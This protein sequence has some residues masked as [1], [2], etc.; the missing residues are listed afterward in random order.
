MEHSAYAPRLGT[1]PLILLGTKAGTVVPQ[2][3]HEHRLLEC[4]APH[5]TMLEQSRRF[6]PWGIL[7]R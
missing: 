2:V 6:R 4:A 3:G 5:S 7:G 1:E